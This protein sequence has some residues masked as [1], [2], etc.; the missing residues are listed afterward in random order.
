M[1][2]EN[3]ANS[4]LRGAERSGEGFFEGGDNF[5]GEIGELRFG[6]RGVVGLEDD[7]DE[8][9]ILSGGDGAAAEEVAGFDGRELGNGQGADFF[10]DLS[11]GDAVGEDEREI[12]FDGGESRNGRVT[13]FCV[14]GFEG[15]AERVE[16]KL[17]EK[18]VLAELEF[19]GE[20]AG[21]LAG[22]TG[23]GRS[24]RRPYTRSQ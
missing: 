14:R 1:T 12:A 8:Q 5:C 17:G 11:E 24:K 10:G 3:L 6:E 13:R 2:R 18:D 9:R 7:A 22:D 19:F 15:F 16:G 20:V 21:E 23:T 4:A